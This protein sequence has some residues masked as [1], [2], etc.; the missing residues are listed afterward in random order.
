MGLRL[1]FIFACPTCEI[2]IA[3]LVVVLYISLVIRVL[4]L[5]I[6]LACF[7]SLVIRVLALIIVLACFRVSLFIYSAGSSGVHSPFPSKKWVIF[8]FPSS[9]EIRFYSFGDGVF[10]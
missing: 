5:I 2:C 10:Y 4:A 7:Q 3:V 9:L 6:V 8:Y 1:L